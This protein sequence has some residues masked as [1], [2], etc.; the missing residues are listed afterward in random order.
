MMLSQN[1]SFEIPLRRGTETCHRSNT[2]SEYV[3]DDHI[4]KMSGILNKQTRS[5]ACRTHLA[6][7][8]RLS[9]RFFL[10]FLGFSLFQLI[11]KKYKGHLRNRH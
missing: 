9:I 3:T 7:N 6:E 10:F 1:I 2:Y 5:Q 11:S 4:V 8:V